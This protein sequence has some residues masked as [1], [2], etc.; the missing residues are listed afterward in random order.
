MPIVKLST[1]GDLIAQLVINT[2]R[3]FDV[4]HITV[5]SPSAVYPVDVYSS[6]VYNVDSE[7]TQPTG[8]FSAPELVSPAAVA[9]DRAGCV[10]VIE[11]TVPGMW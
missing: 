8:H 9:V 11:G 3:I 10:Y 7:S 6:V 4:H 2:R 5:N 1:H